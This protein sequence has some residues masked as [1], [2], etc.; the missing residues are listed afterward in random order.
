[1]KKYEK[2]DLELVTIVDVIRTS[3]YSTDTDWEEGL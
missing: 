2:L 3:D 1:M